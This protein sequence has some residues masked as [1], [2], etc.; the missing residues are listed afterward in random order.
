MR[1]TGAS[2]PIIQ[3]LGLGARNV[4][5]RPARAFAGAGGGGLAGSGAA[6]GDAV[7]VAGG[8]GHSAACDAG[9]GLGGESSDMTAA[10]WHNHFRMRKKFFRT[11]AAAA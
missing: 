4:S 11:L 5:R 10:I 1:L 3:R 2:A 7:A 8:T 9:S 6:A